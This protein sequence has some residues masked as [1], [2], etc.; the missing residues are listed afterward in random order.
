LDTKFSNEF[1]SALFNEM[2]EED[3]NYVTLGKLISEFDVYKRESN[4]II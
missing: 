2:K 4:K 3:G 1:L